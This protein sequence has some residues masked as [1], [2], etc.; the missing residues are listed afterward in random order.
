MTVSA[1]AVGTHAAA[2]TDADVV[3]GR[4]IV[5]LRATADLREALSVHRAA[6][7]VEVTHLYRSALLGYAARMDAGTAAALARRAEVA[8]VEPD[9]IHELAAQTLPTGVDRVDAD[10]SSTAR[11]DGVDQQID[12]DVAVLDTGI[13]LDHPDL[14]VFET[15]AKSCVAAQPTAQDLHGHGT[16]VAGTIGALDNTEGVVGVA[17]G[18]RLWPV[19]VMTDVG[20]GLTSDV[21]CGI[22]YVTQNAAHVEVVNMSIGSAGVFDFERDDRNCGNTN[23]DAYH[24][25]IC[26]SVAAGVTYVVAGGNDHKDAKYQAPA[27]YDEV[28]TVSALADYDGRSGAAASPRCGDEDDTFANF[29]NFGAD[30]DLIAP[31][32]CIYS[33]L[34]L[35][36]YGTMSGTSMASPH[37]AGAAALYAAVHPNATP[38]EVKN[39]LVTLGSKDW[40]WPSQDGDGIQEPLLDVDGAAPTSASTP[41]PTPTPTPTATP[42]PTPTG[43]PRPT[44]TSTASS[45]PTQTSPTPTPGAGSAS[46]SPRAT[47]T[48]SP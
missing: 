22:E 3:A 30:V 27:A 17:P 1:S 33:T 43:S 21:L 10:R 29:S 14:N 23:N 41:T 6:F 5:V 8:W 20:A 48:A 45:T 42:T 4:Y 40:I 36:G 13:D 25:A 28:I 39:G 2:V 31:G 18:A 37:V 11:I 12:A 9:R 19:K 24:R 32:D 46:P 26:S 16:H 7:G 15:G 38:L 44:P 34:P 35:G 47:P